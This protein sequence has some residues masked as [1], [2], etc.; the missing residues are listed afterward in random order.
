MAKGQKRSN[1]E[2]RKP[3]AEER[4]DRMILRSHRPVRGIFLVA[5][6]ALGVSCS[7]TP[8]ASE[9][10]TAVVGAEVSGARETLR[11]EQ[12]R[13]YAAQVE[14]DQRQARLDGQKALIAGSK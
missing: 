14:A 12:F 11:D 4:H 5:A 7:R 10:S 6:T 8:T 9:Q 3:N 1:K 13:A 2:A